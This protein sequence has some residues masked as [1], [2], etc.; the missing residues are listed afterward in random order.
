MISLLIAFINYFVCDYLKNQR[1]ALNKKKV[2]LLNI[3]QCQIPNQNKN[4]Q[5][6]EQDQL[7][8]IYYR[9]KD[10]HYK[11]KHTPWEQTLN[12]QPVNVSI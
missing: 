5:K 8:D 3:Q 12:W 1:K 6:Q 10:H 11:T 4:K 9:N 7:R 2:Q